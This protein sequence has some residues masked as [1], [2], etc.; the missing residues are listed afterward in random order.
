MGI[1][2]TQLQ[3]LPQQVAE[4]QLAGNTKLSLSRLLSTLIDL[5]CT[6]KKRPWVRI[7]GTWRIYRERRAEKHQPCRWNVTCC[8]RNRVVLSRNGC[9]RRREGRALGLW[10]PRWGRK[11]KTEILRPL[12]ETGWLRSLRETVIEDLVSKISLVWVRLDN[13]SQLQSEVAFG[14]WIGFKKTRIMADEESRIP[15]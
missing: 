10:R 2:R 9:A 12:F 6:C 15:N 1:D 14:L 7:I 4:T 13:R 11:I 3:Y 5:Q 8:R